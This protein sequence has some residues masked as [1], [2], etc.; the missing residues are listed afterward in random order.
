MPVN[1]GNNLLMA[2]TFIHHDGLARDAC[3][4]YACDVGASATSA[5]AFADFLQDA[6]A[7]AWKSQLDTSVT[8]TRTTVLLAFAGG[9]P[10]FTTGESTAAPIA[11]TNSAERLPPNCALLV[12][13]NTGVGGRINRGRLYIP[14]SLSDI[15]VD[16]LGN[17]AGG[18]LTP[19]QTA[20]DDW[21]AAIEAPAINMC[22][23]NRTYDRAWDVPNRILT[24]IDA[25][26]H[27]TS[28]TVS[29]IL[30]TQ[31]RRLVRA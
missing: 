27:V 1:Y 2:T 19:R 14:W 12:K 11:G 8:I 24:D 15:D 21:L 13:K 7:D 16:E 28:L 3:V 9:G 20:A 26:A 25:G 22:I 18:A 29:P 17:V 4:T 23:A 10:N 6:F 5:Q 30:A 31:R